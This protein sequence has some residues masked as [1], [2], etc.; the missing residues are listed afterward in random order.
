MAF[1]GLHVTCFDA[2]NPYRAD[3][4]D[5]PELPMSQYWSETLA[6]PGQTT[7]YVRGQGQV[8]RVEASAD[9][10]IAIGATPN[11]SQAVGSNTNT[12]RFLVRAGV[13]YDFTVRDNDKLAW[14]A[15]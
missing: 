15:A 11:A 7:Q 9:S 6:A 14:V 3:R 12:A 1:T 2:G 13:P 10:W 8:F 5:F 4:G